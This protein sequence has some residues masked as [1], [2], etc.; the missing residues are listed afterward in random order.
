MVAPMSNLDFVSIYQED[1]RFGGV[2][3]KDVLPKLQKKY[4]VINLDDEGQP[5]THW[6]AIYNVGSECYYFDPFGVA[7][8]QLA[9][10]RM[11]ETKKPVIQSITELQDISSDYC[12]YWCCFF[13]DSLNNGFSL[14]RILSMFD[15]V[16]HPDQRIKKYAT[17][18]QEYLNV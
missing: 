5:G 7:P 17:C 15:G 12:G 8:P 3:A 4:Y 10:R 2:F 18:I 9:H 11:N 1:K 6:C 13:I 16:A 14:E